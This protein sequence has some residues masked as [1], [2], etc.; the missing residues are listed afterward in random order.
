MLFASTGSSGRLPWLQCWLSTKVSSTCSVCSAGNRFDCL[1]NGPDSRIF[2]YC[3]G[4]Q[5]ECLAFFRLSGH[6]Q[7]GCPVVKCLVKLIYNLFLICICTW[8]CQCLLICVI[9]FR[10]ESASVPVL[11]LVGSGK[12]CDDF[13]TTVFNVVIFIYWF[14]S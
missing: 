5:I 8:L 11:K 14:K 1:R 7:P 9:I 13:L 12:N 4:Y 10:P 2:R 6:H 3:A